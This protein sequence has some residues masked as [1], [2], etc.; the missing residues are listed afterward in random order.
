M[1]GLQ[2]DKK[3]FLSKYW[4]KKPCVIRKGFKSVDPIVSP[5]EL[6]GMACEQEVESRIL[7]QGAGERDWEV[8]YGAFDESVFAQMPESKWTLLIQGVEQWLPEAAELLGEFDFIPNW[9]VDDLMVSYAAPG[10]SVGPHIDHYDVFLIQGV[11]RREWQIGNKPLDEE[12]FIPGLDVKI[13]E[14]F[15]PDEKIILEPGDILYLPPRVA[16]HGVAMEDATTLSVGFRSPHH[17][18]L[19]DGFAQHQAALSDNEQHILD[20]REKSTENSGLFPEEDREKLF[21]L[22]LS[23]ANREAFD[24]WISG[25][26]TSPKRDIVDR[27]SSS[28]DELGEEFEK[29]LGSR[30]LYM[31][32]KDRLLMYV[33]GEEWVIPKEEE[34][35]VRFLTSSQQTFRMEECHGKSDSGFAVQ[36]LE[37]LAKLGHIVKADYE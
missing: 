33:D 5:D 29:R 11:G 20:F 18:E 7:I 35:L 23:G 27:E 14:E 10:G 13:L 26:L 36:F 9:R 34:A 6:A 37:D 17:M 19:L 22:M 31:D 2:L 24:R 3:N 16:H 1:K 32:Q 28:L 25:Y 4:Q 30:W 12:R 15:A 8:K 21:K